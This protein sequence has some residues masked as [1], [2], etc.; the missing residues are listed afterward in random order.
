MPIGAFLGSQDSMH[1]L[2]KPSRLLDD[3]LPD[4]LSYAPMTVNYMGTLR[5]VAYSREVCLAKLIVLGKYVTFVP[6]CSQPVHAS[7]NSV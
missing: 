6:K 5:I 7:A 1:K 3:N 4:I 2:I